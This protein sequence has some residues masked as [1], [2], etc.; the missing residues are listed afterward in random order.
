MQTGKLVAL[1][2]WLWSID[3]NHSFPTEHREL[4]IF[5]LRPALTHL[6]KTGRAQVFAGEEGLV[7]GEGVKFV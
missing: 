7:G 1:G 5:V 4:P 3:I 6:T 2:L